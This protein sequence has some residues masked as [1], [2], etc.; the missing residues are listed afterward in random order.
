M[1]RLDA[2]QGI[3]H[4][5]STL[6]HIR[7]KTSLGHHILTLLESYQMAT[8]VCGNPLSTKV[9]QIYVDSPWVET[10]REFLWSIQA[11]IRIPSLATINPLRQA[12]KCI[13]TQAIR[14]KNFTT[15]ELQFIN[16]CR[17]YL[18]VNY[19]SE[20]CTG[21]GN[22]LLPSAYNGS[23]SEIHIPV[24]WFYFK[25]NVNLASSTLTM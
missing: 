13:M 16:N 23:H 22:R 1:L 9:H 20:I 8:G 5:M 11:T 4:V 2:E 18:Q 15:K 7:A 17:M 12:D 14:S 10:L 21:D 25:V 3:T 6:G 19:L 24:M